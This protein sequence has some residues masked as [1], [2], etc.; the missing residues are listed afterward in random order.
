MRELKENETAIQIWSKEATNGVAVK[1]LVDKIITFLIAADIGTILE[2]EGPTPHLPDY[3]SDLFGTMYGWLI[4]VADADPKLLKEI[5]MQLEIEDGKRIA[6]ID[7]Y[8][9]Y[10]RRLSRKRPS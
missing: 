8:L 9:D 3:F 10:F 1:P 6:D 5:A 4:Y 2:T 7:I